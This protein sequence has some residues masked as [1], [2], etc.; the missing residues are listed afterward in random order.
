MILIIDSG[1]TKTDWVVSENG[2]VRLR[3]ETVGMNPVHMSEDELAVV[4]ANSRIPSSDFG[5][6]LLHVFFYGAGCVSPFKEKVEKALAKSFPGSDVNVESDLLGAARALFGRSSG[7]ACILGTGSNSCLYDGERIVENVPPLGY[8]LGDEGSGTHIGKR[9]LNAIFKGELPASLRDRYLA[10]TSLTYADVIRKVYR[11][12]LANRFL[13]SC[14]L[15]LG[16]CLA[17][18]EID[19]D[20]RSLLRQIVV[21]CFEDFFQKNIARYGY[22]GDTLSVGAIGSIVYHYEAIFRDVA[23]RRACQVAAVAKSPI[24]GLLRF[25]AAE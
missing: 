5:D 21:G 17:D 25:H 6:G 24:E 19:N 3:V 1:S 22:V 4:I 18:S 20:V 16:K 13:A 23:E 7:I 15:F 14:S 11:E 8:I 9:F 10:E 12:P 2:N